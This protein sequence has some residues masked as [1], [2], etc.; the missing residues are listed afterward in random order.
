[1]YNS[2]FINY[3]LSVIYKFPYPHKLTAMGDYGYF[4]G[5]STPCFS[6]AR[7]E[8]DFRFLLDLTW[9][10]CIYGVPFFY[11]STNLIVLH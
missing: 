8:V 7:R 4:F 6:F 11:F 1:M 3:A 2:Y 10:D 5:S 9:C